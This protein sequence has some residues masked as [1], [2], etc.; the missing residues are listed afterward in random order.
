MFWSGSVCGGGHGI[1]TDGRRRGRLAGEQGQALPLLMGL[2]AVAVVAIL[3]LGPLIGAASDKSRAST[4]ADA[5]ALAGAAEG[6]DAAR[7]MAEANGGRLVHY[8]AEGRQVWVSVEVGDAEAV[9]KAE[10]E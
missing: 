10:R 7:A 1:G 6:E 2:L 3:A 9:A 8:V 4:A 5:A